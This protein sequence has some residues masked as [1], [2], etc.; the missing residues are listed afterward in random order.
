MIAAG[1]R[2]ELSGRV[3]GRHIDTLARGDTVRHRLQAAPAAPFASLRWS[4]EVD[5]P[6]RLRAGGRDEGQ[7]TFPVRD[8]LSSRSRELRPL[9]V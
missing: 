7:Q 3:D 9:S 8:P 2:P 4:S 6:T 1:S 5:V